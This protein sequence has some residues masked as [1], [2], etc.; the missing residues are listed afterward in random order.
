MQTF[1]PKFSHLLKARSG[2]LKAGLS[3]IETLVVMAILLLLAGMLAGMLGRF[4]AVQQLRVGTNSA[5]SLF[6]RAR[7]LSLSN[8]GGIPHGVHVGSTTLTL[9]EGSA[10]NESDVNNQ[11]QSLM[12]SLVVAEVTL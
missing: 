7:N 8:D 3:I 11:I 9:F 4:N 1:I 10:Y 12:G 6:E 5:V 2:K